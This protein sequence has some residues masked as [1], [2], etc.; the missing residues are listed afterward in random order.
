VTELLLIQ[1]Q[2]LPRCSRTLL[3]QTPFAQLSFVPTS[4]IPSKSRK[5]RGHYQ[6]HSEHNRFSAKTEIDGKNDADNRKNEASGG[7][8]I[9]PRDRVEGDHHIF[10][11]TGTLLMG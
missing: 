11:H 1:N 9:A 8:Y 5:Q 2:L 7:K 10:V 4:A 6:Q 3:T